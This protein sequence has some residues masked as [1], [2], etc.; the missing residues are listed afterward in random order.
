MEGREDLSK[1]A[2]LIV[3]DEAIVAADLSGK[4]QQLGYDVAG[5]TAKGEDAVELAGSLRPGLVLMDISLTGPMDGIEAAE[6]IRH[7]LDVPVVYLTAHSD[8]ATR[9]R[10]KLSEPFGYILK[11]FE[12]R[13][14]ATNIEMALYRHQSDRQLREQ[15][16]KLEARTMELQ[17]AN[18]TLRA[19][20]TAALNLTE[21]A[22]VARERAEKM[23]LELKR[24]IAERKKVE[25]ALRESEQRLARSQEIAHLGSWELDLVKN[26]LTWS[27]EIYRI[28]GIQPQEFGATY[29][30]FLERIHPD[31]RTAV[32]EAYRGS[33]REGKDSYDIEHRI[34]RKGTGDV[35]WVSERCQHVR[36]ATGKIVCSIGMIHDITERK[37]A[38]EEL[39]KLTEDLKRSN[40]DLQQFAYIASHDL[41]SPLRSVEGFVKLLARRY[42]GQIDEKAD[43]FILHICNGVK[44]MQML[45]HDILEYS[46]IGS[47]GSTFTSRDMTSC[48]NQALANL[49]AEIAE[50]NADIVLDGPMPAVY[51][52]SIQL[53]S[54][55]QNLIGNAV[56]FS[57]EQSRIR[58]SAKREDGWWVFSV[59][60]NGI[61]MEPEDTGK[62]FAVFHRLHSKSDY[63]GT[64][65][66]LAI[67]KR[68]VERHGGRIW[69]ESEPGKGSTF[70]FT[71]PAQEQKI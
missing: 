14:L 67:C 18:E 34:V 55:F 21:D 24:E 26:K 63:Q 52:D 46:K 66:G 32:D 2:I 53:V 23:T 40:S 51:G 6:A 37:K 9:S 43:E 60:D 54:L 25:E 47:E 39:L 62:I 42:K 61:G 22:I 8:A 68:I 5:I 11:P 20:R 27:D 7:Q 4:L 71:L 56:K 12:E 59:T 28:F 41:Q 64:G 45:I 16:D 49:K 3:E 70:Y 13:E 65:I 33:V 1:T 50:K 48:V 57:A 36:D 31:D 10:A 38:E 35:R 44:D 19:S 58:I 17:S 29:E 30:A 69:V 15:R